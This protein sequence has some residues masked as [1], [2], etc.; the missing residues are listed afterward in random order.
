MAMDSSQE[1][2]LNGSSTMQDLQPTQTTDGYKDLILPGGVP[3]YSEGDAKTVTGTTYRAGGMSGGGTVDSQQGTSGGDAGKM[4]TVV[5]QQVTVSPGMGSDLGVQEYSASGLD[6]VTNDTYKTTITNQAIQPADN[7][8]GFKISAAGL[9]APAD[10]TQSNPVATNNEHKIAGGA[11]FSVSI[12]NDGTVWTWGE[13]GYGQLGNS[14]TENKVIPNQIMGMSSVASVSAGSYHAVALKNDGT[15]WTWGYNRYGQL[16]NGT[17]QYRTSPVEVSGLSDV[18]QISAGYYHTA[19]LKSDGTVWVWGYNGEG[20]LGD[21]T[22]TN[23]VA[24]VQVQGISDIKAIA[25]GGWHTVAIKSDGTVWAWGYNGQ[26]QLGD[27]TETNRTSPVQVSSLTDIV[28]VS[29]GHYHTIAVKSNG[30]AFSWGSNEYGQLGDGTTTNKLSPV[31][32]QGLDNISLVAGG[33]AHTMAL[34]ND[35]MVYSWG[36]NTDSQLG[37]GST[38]NRSYPSQVYQISNVTAIAAGYYH[39]LALKSDGKVWTWGK[40]AQS[41]LGDG[42]NSNKNYPVLSEDAQA[43][44]APTALKARSTTS[45]V[46]LTWLASTDNIGVAGYQIFRNGAIIGTTTAL[47][48][49]DDGLSEGN[50]YE[51]VVKAFDTSGNVSA[52]SNSAAYDTQVPTAPANLNVFTKTKTNVAL[53]WSVS[54]DNIGVVRYEI[55]RD[56]TKVGISTVN[57][58]IDNSVE[59]GKTYEY[60]VKAYDA[61][62]NFSDLSNTISVTIEQVWAVKSVPVAGGENHTVQVKPDGTVWTYGYNGNGQLGDGTYTQRVAPVKVEGISDVI[63]VACGPHHTAALKNDGTV[64]TWGYNGYGQLGIGSW[65]T[66]VIPTQVPGLS[67]VVAIAA[68]YTNTFALK[69]DGTVWSWGAG[70]Y[71]QLGDGTSEYRLSP[72]QVTGIDSVISISAYYYHVLALKSDGTVWAWGSNWNGE[73]GDG[74][75]QNRFSPVQV[76]GLSGITAIA[77][78]TN[79]SVALKSDGTL[80]VWGYNGYGQF[81]NGT[82]NSSATPVQTSILTGITDIAAGGNHTLALRNDGTVLA[83]GLNEY[84]QLGNGTSN[85]SNP[86]PAAVEGLTEITSLGCGDS[87]SLAVKNDGTVLSWGYNGYGQIGSGCT[88]NRNIPGPAK[89]IVPPE[90]PTGLK[91]VSTDTSAKLTWNASSDIV[92][93]TGYEVYRD[94]TKIATVTETTYTDMSLESGTTYT[95]VVKAIDAEGNA[96]LESNSVINDTQSPT[97][98]SGLEAYSKTSGSIN[99]KWDNSTDNVLVIGYEVYRDGIKVGTT[100]E[101]RFNDSGLNPDTTYSYTVK[102]YDSGDNLSEASNSISETT[103]N[104]YNISNV[105]ISAG[106]NHSLMI[107]DDAS[108]YATGY[109]GN[110]ELGNGTYDQRITFV[111]VTGFDSVAAVSSGPNHSAAIKKDGTVW[112]WGYNGYGQLG[113]GTWNCRNT[114]AQ[115][116]SLSNTSAVDVGQVH[117]VALK[118]DETV[119][120]WGTNWYGQLGDGTWDYR[121]SPVQ[122]PGISGVVSIAAGNYHTLALKSDGTV[123]VWGANWYGQLGDGTSQNRNTPVRVQG[124][125]DVI[126]ISA[127]YAHSLALKSDGTVWAWGYNGYGELGD[128]TW[129]NSYTPVQI[130]SLTGITAIGAGDYHS[131]AQKDDGTVWAWGYNGYGQLGDGTTNYRPAPVQVSGLTN[132]IEI[133]SGNYHCLA[134]KDDGTVWA[135]GYNNY[136]QLGDGTT[137]Y[138][139]VPVLAQDTHAPTKPTGLVSRATE[140]QVILTWGQASDQ[141]GV[142]GYEVYRDNEK[143]A[144]VTETT[145]TD[146]SVSAGVTYSY[147][148][149]AFDAAGN[150]SEASDAVVNDIQAPMAPEGLQLTTVSDISSSLSWNPS[151]DNVGVIGYKIYRDG[152]ELES[153]TE[154]SYTDSGLQPETTYT[155]TIKAYDAGGNISESSKPLTVVTSADTQSPSQP[156]NLYRSGGTDTTATISWSASTDDVGVTA[157]KIYRDGVEIAT[158]IDTYYYDSGV[159]LGKT[160]VYT[161]KACDKAGNESIESSQLTITDE[162][163][164]S[165]EAATPIQNGI[166]VS[167]ITNYVNDYDFFSF[168]TS[169]AGTYYIDITNPNTVRGNY[170][171]LYDSNGNLLTYNGYYPWWWGWYP[172]SFGISYSL[173]ASQT[174]YVGVTNNFNE[175]NQSYSIRVD[176]PPAAP[177]NLNAASKSVSTVSLTW[178]AAIDDVGVAGYEVY[179]NGTMIKS[180]TSTAIMDTGLSPETTYTYFV[181]AYDGRNNFSENSETISVTTD[182]DNEAPTA[183]A[184]LNIAERTQNSVTLTWKTSIDNISVAGYELYR[185]GTKIATVTETTYTDEGLEPGAYTYIVKAFD[186]AGNLSDGSN[187]V[188]YDNK[189]PSAPSSIIVT[190]KTATTVSLTWNAAIDNIKVTGYE[191]YRN[192]TKVGTAPGTSYTD[193][194]LSEGEYVY[195][196][197][198]FDAAGNLSAASASFIYDR[199]P[200]AAPQN[201][202]IASKT[203]SSITIEWSASTDNVGATGYDIFRDG[204]KIGSTD[205]LSFT[206]TG[207]SQNTV[208]V[209]TIKAKDA[210]GNISSESTPL[211]AKVQ[212]DT[213]APTVPANLHFTVKTGS[214]VALEWLPSTDN[215]ATTAYIICRDGSDIGE[216]TQTGYVDTDLAAGT[217]YKYIVK[218]KDAAGNT[219]LASNS[220]SVIPVMPKITSVEPSNAVTIGGAVNQPTYIYFE[221]NGGLIGSHAILEYSKDGVNWVEASSYEYVPYM[222]SSDTLVIRR[223]WD[224]SPLT[225]GSYSLRYTLYDGANNTDQFTA[226][227]QVD[228]TAPDA[229]ANF[230]A[231]SEYGHILLAWDA[232]NADTSYYKVYCSENENG[233]FQNITNVYGRLN[234]TFNHVVEPLKTYYYKVS[235]VDRFSQ[236]G[237]SSV[238]TSGAAKVDTVPPVV[239]AI[240]PANDTKFGKNAYI[241]VKAEDNVRLASVTLQY[242][243]N[244]TDWI[245]IATNNTSGDTAFN[246]NTGSLNGEVKVR[247]IAK[248]SSGISSDGSVQRTY[249]ID[250]EGPSKVTGLSAVPFQNS[251]TLKWGDVPDQDFGYFVVERK[252]TAN[253]D[254]QYV[255]RTDTTL[256]MNIAGLNCNTVYTY[257]VVAYDRFDNRGTESDELAVTTTQDTVAP[258]VTRI[259]PAPGYYSGAIPLRV[260]ASD[261]AGISKVLLQV[262]TDKVNWADI[263]DLPASGTPKDAVLDF[264]YDISSKPEGSYYIRGIAYDTSDLITNPAKAGYVEYRIDKTAPAAPL[265]LTVASETGVN[266][267]SWE[268]GTESDINYFKIYRSLG[269]EGQYTLLADRVTSL[270]YYD[271]DVQIGTTYYYKVSTVDLA[272][273]EGA[274]TGPQSGTP[275]ED[276]EAPKILSVSYGNDATLPTNPGLSV[277]ASDNYKLSKITIEFKDANKPDDPWARIGSKDCSSYSEVASIN[278]NT[279]G[280]T[281]G[282]Y[283]VRFTAQDTNGNTSVPTEVSYNLNLNPPQVPVITAT[284]GDWKVSLSWTS[285]NEYDLRGFN[286]YRS[287]T[288]GNGYRLIA[289]TSATTYSDEMLRPGKTYY[290]MVEAL[291][292]YNNVSSSAEAGVSPGENDL[293]A[294]VAQAGD[295]QFVTEGMEVGFDALRST[296]NDRIVSYLWNFGDGETSTL[297]QPTHTYAATGEYTVTLAVYD[298]CGNS[299]TDTS[300]VTVKPRAQ[301]GML[302]VRV[303]DD[304]NASPIA[305]ASVVVKY[306]DGTMQKY[307]TDGYGIATIVSA[308]GS[309]RVYAYKTDYKP[310]AVDAEFVLNQKNTATIMLEKG[311]IIRGDLTVRRMKLDE[312]Q[313]AGIDVTAPEN[314]W[315]Y[316][317]EVHLA[318]VPAQDNRIIVNGTG[319]FLGGSSGWWYYPSGGGG[320]S[321]SGGGYY[322]SPYV[323]PNPGHP[324]VP[325]TVMYLV[326]PGEARWLKEFFEVTLALEN[327]ASPEFVLANSKATLNLPDGLVLAPTYDS[328][329]LEVNLGDIAGKETRQVKWIIRGDKKG[330]YD[331]EANFKGILQPFGDEVN[332]TFKTKEPFKVWGEDALRMHV[333][334][335]DRADKNYPY[336]VRFELEN[337]ADIPV[338]YPA[339]E[340]KENGKLNYIYGP[341]QQLTKTVTELKPGEKLVGEYR[342]VP[343]ISGILDLSQ[344]FIVKTGGNAQVQ[345]DISSISVPQNVPGTAPV[346]TYKHN[347]GG[348]VTLTWDRVDGA[349]KYRIYTIRDDTYMSTPAEMV[350]EADADTNTITI[351]EPAGEKEYLI[352][353]VTAEG[354][355]LRHG[356]SFKIIDTQAPS[357]P[358]GLSIVST[359]E[360]SIT[361]KWNASK[362]NV[363]VKEYEVYCDGVKVGTTQ[364]T[365]YTSFALASGTYYTFTVKAVDEGGNISG[366][367]AGITAQTLVTAVPINKN[368]LNSSMIADNDSDGFS[369]NFFKN[370]GAGITANYSIDSLEQAQKISIIASTTKNRSYEYQCISAEPGKIYSMKVESK[371]SGDVRARAQIDWFG[372]NGFIAASVMPYYLP[373]EL[374]A[375]SITNVKAPQGT[376]YAKVLWIFEPI[377]VGKTGTVWFKNASFEESPGPA[378]DSAFLNPLLNKDS[379]GNGIADSFY[380]SKGDGVSTVCSIDNTEKAQKISIDASTTANRVYLYQ[381]V[382]VTPGKAYSLKVE[383]KVSGNVRIRVQI[384]WYSGKACIGAFS[385]GNFTPYDFNALTV[386]NKVAPSGATH[387]KIL[388]V[389]EPLSQGDIGAAWFK[390]AAFGESSTPMPNSAVLNPSMTSDDNMNGIADSYNWSN[391]NG[392]TAQCSMDKVENAQKVSITASTTALRSHFYQ[393]VEVMPGAVYNLGVEGKV[394]GNVRIKLQV[395]WYNGNNFISAVSTPYVTANEFTTLTLSN[396][397]SPANAAYAKILLVVEPLNSGDTGEAWF[398]NLVL[399]K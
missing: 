317:F 373:S 2:L 256:G 275:V 76:A 124:L 88:E 367:S 363:G 351:P 50:S 51:Y 366:E 57:S 104:S 234:T 210:N 270:G 391:G 352:N 43:P 84:G 183:P 358:D 8:D 62:D 69:D 365:S 329:S 326:I 125:T 393:S 264:G 199:L 133:E 307:T 92:G 128:G 151:T 331:L 396:K 233:P 338:Y 24:P 56:G 123:W 83:W 236:E 283:L 268:K 302:E 97:A 86:N 344:S 4:F 356:I 20:E 271:R 290:Y 165:M 253:G 336:Y 246:W 63:A 94:G 267:L 337:V 240:I 175:Y 328:Q 212:D 192:G 61:G 237:E 34:R 200:P 209:Y 282:K 154:L 102:A 140:T 319:Q 257:R 64:W 227:Y 201:L 146:L 388:L 40:N 32:I 204:S 266:K 325:P 221:N 147:T 308:P 219:S 74:T 144:T 316:E 376:T 110:G 180:T 6:T 305:G 16:G 29:A 213:D 73:L 334:A 220:V 118:S 75:W 263:A 36:C 41:Q 207:V 127:G 163:S 315:V 390:N 106:Y 214:T 27:G 197:K 164:G 224:L 89:D 245:D 111:K 33:A 39:S 169:V 82:W 252:D 172:G 22:T 37:D 193:S 359:S 42:T 189:E 153:I 167:G 279:A 250:T 152:V 155:Y 296:D 178:K 379:D 198:A 276:N 87:Y 312:I 368:L 392:I 194:G 303:L 148:V 313:A 190:A 343:S 138:R 321:G 399:T 184:N 181:R 394:S 364:N 157:Y 298:A 353:T 281:E 262:S 291:D 109:N 288:S 26:G 292:Q 68:G 188:V 280:L 48:Y 289:Q 117:T 255:G 225:S 53:T 19:A 216:T 318:F 304:S 377:D 107:S 46:S 72:V 21:G 228:R 186:D 112:T 341:N 168:K 3:D 141:A 187:L 357:V 137:E 295:D 324:E 85:W 78:G 5:P 17:I 277:L 260:Y 162:Y 18:V 230:T 330:T 265:S 293:Y 156:Q 320:S 349:L 258:Y 339:I 160:Y 115:I 360:T 389:L 229:P 387:A 143:I 345:S 241:T 173:A 60:S 299:G 382:N 170:L 150:L 142:T 129:Q 135:W 108:V 232:A 347:G 96:S 378:P 14:S 350:Y 185:D 66:R 182:P 273:N 38:N 309:Y 294:P 105:K 1:T 130:T 90:K 12:R 249:V 243:L 346:L 327:T 381:P 348:T 251:I 71:G 397:V 203:V 370:T 362:D 314:Q 287:E 11:G 44:S 113:D 239:L 369:D 132:V 202:A 395:D 101:T 196:V 259:D 80:W 269:S 67:G 205:G 235:A 222:V 238:V 174:Y 126:A 372:S 398:K 70:W 354:E 114:P 161:V 91:A 145:Y 310:N 79:H 28:S 301:V 176:G 47:N 323:V 278:W 384:D 215:I 385:S 284:P 285:A 361:L 335:Q 297:A 311:E 31:Q 231:A 261:N 81:G 9:A 149:K 7:S 300:I 244:G 136:G 206:D 122:V 158:T 195:C 342:L 100:T 211:N 179:R 247:A 159:E 98:P 340:L 30:I 120:T 218:A 355:I 93:V 103:N 131:L 242:S 99:L 306:S 13:N 134:K 286:V 55:Y 272:G 116:P 119:W 171:Y 386:I 322:V 23:R 374:T 375:I 77:A 49:I 332:A 274:Q 254:F 223:D 383:G 59:S 54:T 177:T 95:Y 333:I 10:N 52:A 217:E 58:Y 226:T 380:I 25:C 35:G 191:I 121:L 208:Y 139:Y 15:V 248:D 45:S 166:D 65:E 371:V